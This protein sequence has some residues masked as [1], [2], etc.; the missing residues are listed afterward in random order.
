MTK[1]LRFN[2]SNLNTGS[3]DDCHLDAADPIHTLKAQGMLGTLT[4]A[5]VSAAYDTHQRQ[6]IQNEHFK[7]RDEAKRLGIRPGT[8][9]WFA[10]NQVRSR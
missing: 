2:T 3:N 5:S 10:L 1:E 8:P 4:P 9:A 6:Q 7:L